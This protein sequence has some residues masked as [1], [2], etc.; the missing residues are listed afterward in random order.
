MGLLNSFSKLRRWCTPDG[1]MRRRD[2]RH[3][4]ASSL[5]ICRLEQLESRQLMAADLHLGSVFYEPH[6][7]L[8]QGAGNTIQVSFDGGAAGTQLTHLVIDGNKLLDGNL[9]N[10]DIFFDTATGGLGVYGT[11]PLVT[12]SHTGF[13]ITNVSVVDGGTQIAFDFSG[14]TAGMK[15]TFTVDADAY[16]VATVLGAAATVDGNE[17]ENSHL[18]GTFTA[19]HYQDITLTA[20][21]YDEFDTNFNTANQQSGTVLNLPPDSY[22]PNTVGPNGT[23]IDETVFTA[24][25]VA[26]AP[27]IPLP[28]SLAGRVWDDPNLDLIQQGTET[29]I[30]GV[31]VSLLQ[32]N[33]S[34]YLSTGLTQTTDANGD[35][36]F[37]NLAP[38]EYRV[39]ETQPSGYFSVGDVPGTVN[40]TTDGATAGKDILT[41]VVLQGG[42]DSVHNNF[43]EAQP[44]AVSGYVYHDQNNN[45]VK[46]A[47]EAGI[48]NVQLTITPVSTLDPSQTAVTVTTDANGFYNATGLSPGQY[49]V[50]EVQP[51]GWIDGLD[52]AGDAGGAAH[53]PGDLITGISLIG[54]QA[55]HNY[56]FGELLPAQLSGKVY[57]DRNQDCVFNGSD[58]PLANVS[59]QLLDTN[60]NVIATTTTDANGNYTFSN[61][62]PGV[63]HVREIQ[64]AG[65]LDEADMVGTAGGTLLDVNNIGQ[66]ALT[67][68]LNAQ[69]Y[70]FCEVEPVSLAGK[71]W[72]D[73]E[74]DCVYGPNDIPL[75]NVTIQLL[76]SQGN[77]IRT[78]LTDA[79]GNYKFDNLAPGTYGVHEVQPAGFYQGM[80][81]AGSAGGDD[82]IQDT[83]TQVVLTP[84]T[85]ATDYDFCEELPASL[86][87]H[88]WADP[89]ADCIDGPNDIPLQ[90]VTI[91]LLDANG[92]I[93]T[94]TLTDSQGYYSFD[95][96]APGLYSVHEVQPAGYFQGM[97]MVGSAGGL[98]AGND[99]LTDVFL[100]SD[101]HATDYDFCEIIPSSIAGKVWAD[102][103][104][105][106]VYGPNDTP[107]AGVTIQLLDQDGNVLRTTQTDAN[108]NYKFDNLAPGT[109]G[110]HELQPAGYYQGGEMVG[111]AGGIDAGQDLLSGITLTS[112]TIAE[113]YNFC[114]ILPSRI[115]GQVVWTADGNCDSGEPATP[116]AGVTIQLLDDNGQILTTT[117]T[118]ANG[119]YAF[120]NLAPG[121]YTVH[122]V[123]PSD[124][125][126]GA[127]Y[128]G[129]AGGILSDDTASQIQ[130]I[131]GTNGEHYDF[132]EMPPVKLSG[133]VFQDGPTIVVPFGQTAPSIPS[134]RTGIKTP[135]DTPIQGV[136]MHLADA[137]GQTVYDVNGN[138]VVT[139]TDAN[140][141][142][143]FDNLPPGVFTVVAGAPA[144]YIPGLDTPGT[145]GGI[146]IN[147]YNVQSLSIL[148][149]LST[150]SIDPNSDA[151]VRIPVPAGSQSENNNFSVVRIINEPPPHLI[152]PPP[153]PPAPPQFEVTPPPPTVAPAVYIAPPIQVYVQPADYASHAEGWTWHLSV[154]N[155]GSPRGAED[156]DEALVKLVNTR[157]DVFAMNNNGLDMQQSTWILND[158]TIKA[159]QQYIFGIPGAIPVTG[160]F[161]G[162]GVT[163]IGVYVDGEWFIDMNGN[164][165]WDAGDLYLKLGSA[166]DKPVVGDW[167][168]DGK[169]DIGIFGPQW[170]L[171]PRHLRREGG[172]PDPHNPPTG[173]KKNI[174][175]QPQEATNGVRAIK[176]G[177]HGKVRADLIDHVFEYGSPGDVPVSGDWDGSGISRIGVF[178]HGHWYLDMDGNG[179]WSPGDVVVDFGQAGDIPVVG[180]WTGDGITKIGVYRQGK[181][182][183]DTNNNR[184]IDALD[185][186]FEMGGPD[187]L[188]VVGDWDG[189]GKAN[190]GVYHKGV[191][192]KRVSTEP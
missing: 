166:G 54:G 104:G 26:V 102:P 141:Y 19:P 164:G 128:I 87:G 69:H 68:G 103:E 189:S 44:A 14:F 23:S 192:E 13:N 159:P 129:T 118:D 22:Q 86:S 83:I 170:A 31:Q 130:L 93:V 173:K 148:S 28:A 109:Y 67:S 30:A 72:A 107:L 65:Y 117:L 49:Q 75:A 162:D 160:D 5:R 190:V 143:E 45:G 98:D 187:D 90:G 127:E 76:D 154:I 16:E 9:N 11:A 180:D 153:P 62:A 82:S 27:Q 133:Y 188:P 131:S 149:L 113:Q 52:A 146:A 95:D 99:L 96:L 94:T 74:G 101:Q 123:Q 168:G 120:E 41:D 7:G 174:P 34:Q 169:A 182:I 84:S 139:T 8:D 73:P 57:A 124:Y 125:Y 33:G 175:P 140:G 50:S 132:C 36:K 151:L 155:G 2:D 12:I 183:L 116:I 177:A 89:E 171:D 184:Q 17:F 40:G 181:W 78:T 142:Y 179:K 66:I 147:R 152:P 178:R 122:E 121:S 10:G 39:V 42:E 71:V 176:L 47:G 165:V 3:D 145:T 157:L 106:C 58:V 46:D 156:V 126:D 80:Q 20:T 56:D 97:E 150:L 137:S 77:V 186:V 55:G 61:L 114:E 21:Y 18:V 43:A 53:N 59:M 29:G 60:N 24:G 115:S 38:G 81:M 119:D 185:R 134:V 4:R 88:V 136:V 70:D 51:A 144:G 85:Q 100:S 110:V 25:A 161:A 1:K 112:G 35:Y 105:D 92:A 48:G 63:Y 191:I 64:P 37:N 32:W 138:P 108:G 91:Q 15:L 6:Q 167:D 172:L 79:N 163:R 135:D 158:G 111:S